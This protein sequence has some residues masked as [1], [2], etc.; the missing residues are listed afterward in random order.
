MRTLVIGTGNKHKVVEITPHFA[1][2]DLTL[3]AAGEYGSFNPD[4][5]GT[6]LE[7][8]AII[9][10]QAAMKLSGEWAIA[11]DTGLEIDALG[12]R[13]GIYAARYAGPQCNFE[14]NIRKVLDE[15]AGVPVEKRGA[16][17]LCV[18]A[19]CR[20]GHPPQTFRG[21]CPGQ[22]ATTRRGAGGFG[23]D[24]IYIVSGLNKTFA[25]MTAD[26]KNSLSHRALATKLC[27]AELERLLALG[28]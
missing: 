24:P 26:E 17:F 5:N 23:Y 15:M 2:L 13:P 12:G 11:D 19:L 8:N 10:A 3:K 7:A 20:P 6:T 25:E 21:V 4:E 9:K 16:K 18:I 27:R 22:I 1:G 14:D 28:A